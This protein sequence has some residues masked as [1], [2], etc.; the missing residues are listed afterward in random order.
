MTEKRENPDICPKLEKVRMCFHFCFWLV[1]DWVG[2]TVPLE[3]I[4]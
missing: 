1:L 3:Q 2:T 4:L